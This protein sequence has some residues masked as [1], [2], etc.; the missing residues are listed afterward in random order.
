MQAKIQDMLDAIPYVRS[1]GMCL[2]ECGDVVRVRMPGSP[3]NAN[4]F[5]S[6]HA[7]ALYCAAETAAG[8]AAWLLR[9]EPD[10]VVL[11]HDVN[12]SYKA[13]ALGDVTAEASLL[14]LTGAFDTTGRAQAQVAVTVR[15]TEGVAVLEAAFSYALRRSSP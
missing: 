8:V 7:A 5:G 3:E 1:H 9:P 14:S 4:M 11:V 12:M 6:L 13:K 10:T 2:E 15:D